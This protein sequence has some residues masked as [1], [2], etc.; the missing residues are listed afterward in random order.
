VFL[1]FWGPFARYDHNLD[2]LASEA[3]EV[4]QLDRCGSVRY[5]A[6]KI[7]AQVKLILPVVLLR[8]IK[9]RCAKVEDLAAASVDAHVEHLFAKMVNYNQ[10]T[11]LYLVYSFIKNHHIRP[12]WGN[13]RRIRLRTLSC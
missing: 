11:S 12:A 7:Y 10:T 1:Q 9:C 2:I 3:L 8:K 6:D 5:L 4:G 13:L